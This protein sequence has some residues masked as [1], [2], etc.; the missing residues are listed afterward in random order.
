MVTAA[1]S[2]RRENKEERQKG[3][4]QAGRGRASWA[5][6]KPLVSFLWASHL[7]TIRTVS[8]IFQ[9]RNHISIIK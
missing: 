5:R 7:H 2:A 9:A 1:S 6:A 4:G 3:W 8:Q